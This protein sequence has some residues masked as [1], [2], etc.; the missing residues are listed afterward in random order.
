[1]SY[2]QPPPDPG[3]GG[4]P[5]PYG[6]QPGGYGQPQPQPGGY[7]QHPPQQ[8]GYGQQPPQQPGY[9]YP[10]QPMQ[11]GSYGQQPQ[12]GY[13]YPPQPPAG[14]KNTTWIVI[15]VVVVVLALGGGAFALLGGG[16][17]GSSSGSDDG[18]K[19]K[20]TT[21]QT[22]AADFQLKDQLSD[23][24]KKD[25]KDLPGVANPEAAGGSYETSTKKKMLFRGVWGTVADPEK[26]V[27]ALFVAGTKDI[28]KGGDAELVGSPQ[29]ATPDGL[30]GGAVMK[31]QMVKFKAPATSTS[32]IKSAN[33]PLCIW[34]DHSTVA[35]VM[36][37]DPVAALTGGGPSIDDTAATTA[38]V[39]KDARVEIK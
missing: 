12:P 5:N 37:V 20:L 8:A 3:Y 7:G 32:P 35:M 24:D 11:P 14:K 17:K 19:Y 31:C 26:E 33:V 22:V 18:K 4:Q 6:Q 16:G 29:K 13:G 10:A 34:A 9:G 28:T 21:P 23:S 39:R 2:N 36:V 15:A 38:K 1:M 30:D 25:V 27:D